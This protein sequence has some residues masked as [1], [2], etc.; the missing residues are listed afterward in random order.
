MITVNGG[1]DL[2]LEHHC[3][4]CSVELV[5]DRKI[6]AAIGGEVQPFVLCPPCAS[7]LAGKLQRRLADLGAVAE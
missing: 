5:L 2:P 4:S 6:S 1:S 3:T 7:G